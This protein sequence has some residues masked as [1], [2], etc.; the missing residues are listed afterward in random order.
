MMS[1]KLAANTS[2]KKND[3]IL[4]ESLEKYKSTNRFITFYTFIISLVTANALRLTNN[5]FCLFSR[6]TKLITTKHRQ[7]TKGEPPG[8]PHQGDRCT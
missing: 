6:Q 2:T 4:L 1:F 3:S 5:Q 7:L 8:P